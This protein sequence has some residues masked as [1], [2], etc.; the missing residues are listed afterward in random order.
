[1]QIKKN[2]AHKVVY[3]NTNG[4]SD[5]DSLVPLMFATQN[6]LSLDLQQ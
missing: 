3:R 4:A 1:M 6:D 2:R 5:L